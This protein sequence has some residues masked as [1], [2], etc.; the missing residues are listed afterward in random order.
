MIVTD[1]IGWTQ[2]AGGLKLEFHPFGIL[3]CPSEHK[4]WHGATPHEGTTH[5]A[6]QE[7]VN[8]TPGTWMEKA[9]TQ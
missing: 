9:G 8:G 4:H 7:A 2:I 3:W 6:I 5:V 1:G